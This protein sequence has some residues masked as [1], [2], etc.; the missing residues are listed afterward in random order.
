MGV[1]GKDVAAFRQG[2]RREILGIRFRA[3]PNQPEPNATHH[4][5]HERKRHQGPVRLAR[6]LRPLLDGLAKHVAESHRWCSWVRTHVYSY[7]GWWCRV[8][9]VLV[10]GSVQTT[11]SVETNDDKRRL[12]VER[13][14]RWY[15]KFWVQSGSSASTHRQPAGRESRAML[16]VP[17]VT[18][19]GELWCC[20]WCWCADRTSEW[21]RQ[22]EFRRASLSNYK[23]RSKICSMEIAISWRAAWFLKIMQEETKSKKRSE[24]GFGDW[25]YLLFSLF[26]DMIKQHCCWVW[27]Q[28]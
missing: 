6:Y 25:F 16:A 5:G 9:Y 27:V 4:Q 23:A 13:A 28:V 24:I 7:D 2:R 22:A 26:Y 21:R 17:P 10:M 15:K 18:T 20:C 12:K 3:R 11:G 8:W 1:L 14:G 19:Q